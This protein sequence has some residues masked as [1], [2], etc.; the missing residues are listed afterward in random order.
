MVVP[1]HLHFRLMDAYW[2]VAT[3]GEGADFTAR[4]PYHILTRVPSTRLKSI[5]IWDIE[6]GAVVKD[7]MISVEG[8]REI[9]FSG[10]YTVTL[11]TGYYKIFRTY[12][13]LNG[14]LLYEGWILPLFD[15]WLGAYWEHGES[16]RL[17]TSY[18]TDSGKLAIDIH[19]LQPSSIPP[20]TMV[21]SFV[22]PLDN[23]DFSLSPVSFHASFV[24]RTEITL[25]DIR[26]SKILLRTEAPQPL[27]SMLGRFSPDGG[28][29]AC[30]TLESEIHIWKNTPA[31]Y[32][33][34]SNLKPRLPFDSFSFSPSA[35]S[36]L[37]W[38][39]GGVQLLDNR[40]RASS[41]NKMASSCHNGGHLVAYSKDGTRI[42]T[43]RLGD[44]VVT[45]LDLLSGTPQR[46]INTA[47][48]ILDIGIIGNTV[49]TANTRELVGW[50]PELG[51]V[52]RR[53]FG[54]L[55]TEIAVTGTDPGLV[56]NFTLSADCSWIA[57]T[58]DRTILLYDIQG[59]RVLYKRTMDRDV[60]DIR[61]APYGRELCFILDDDFCECLA[62]VRG[63]QM[64][65]E[66][67]EQWRIVNVTK[68][69]TEGVWSRDGLFPLHGC[70]IQRELGWIQDSGGRKLLWLPPNWRMACCLA[71]RWN[72]NFLALVDGRHPVPIIIAFRPQPLPLYSIQSDT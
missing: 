20:F 58:V 52:A 19:Q 24:T 14:V 10:S 15:R 68:E 22:V 25:L 71:T 47:M 32:V 34:W 60:V 45:V 17:A 55:V 39:P 26:D 5:V 29:F 64:L 33:P 21:E 48:R 38:G 51:E 18:A 13:A 23:E 1:G 44:N 12:D 63:V 3:I 61:F 49:F 31:G 72:G 69:F 2:P 6:T 42:A 65:S 30:G 37:A 35:V 41:S 9:V 70:C 43:A 56:E 62:G 16:L 66:M 54:A 8:L 50:D 4:T 11:V 59:Q 40:T 53:A 28:F 27:Y 7:I 67:A 36:I 46:P 57:F